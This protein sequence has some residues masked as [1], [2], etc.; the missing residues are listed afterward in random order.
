MNQDFKCPTSNMFKMIQ[1]PKVATSVL[2]ST[3]STAIRSIFL[4]TG[5]LNK[6]S[7]ASSWIISA[8]INV[9]YFQFTELSVSFPLQWA[10]CASYSSPIFP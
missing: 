4:S 8:D 3:Q 6:V 5:P 10:S 1:E 2:D 9:P 7:R